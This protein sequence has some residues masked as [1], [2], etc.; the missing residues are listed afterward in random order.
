MFALPNRSTG[1]SLHARSAESGFGICPRETRQAV[2]GMLTASGRTLEGYA[3]VFGVETRVKDF[4]EVVMPGAFAASLG[5]DVLALVDHDPGKV[6]G[7][8]RSGTLRLREDSKGL[9]FS[10]ALPDTTLARDVLEM[11]K[12]G[13][14]GG[15]S[16]AFTVAP[17]GE[18]WQ[19]ARPLRGKRRELRAV[20]LHE[21]SVVS[22]W[23]AYQGTEVHAR[24]KLPPKVMALQRL[25]DTL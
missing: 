18:T 19:E 16:F 17:G 23:P 3:A 20:T 5:R 21:I 10:V 15:C 14:M 7:R 6:L 4:R 25:L 8:T 11:V 13:D 24:A 12:R 9:H 22:A 1:E 2:D